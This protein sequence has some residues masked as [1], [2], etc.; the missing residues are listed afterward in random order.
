[1]RIDR[2]LANMGCGSRTEVKQLIKSGK[3]KVNG[4]T[5]IDPGHQV[6]PEDDEIDLKGDRIVY[7]EFL[8][9][10]MNKPA[11]VISAT[12][13][14]KEQTVLDLIESKY[15]NKGLFPVGRLD[16]DTEGLL[17]LTNH[18]ELGHQLLSPKKHVYKKYLARIDGKVTGQ[19]QVAFKS[20]IELDDGY[21]TLPGDLEII[22][23]G[24]VS[25]VI[26]KIR[27]CKFHQ[28]KRMF[29]AL[30]KRVVYL[31]RISMGGL[32]LD[33]GLNPGEYRE[34]TN[35]EVKQLSENQ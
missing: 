35:G 10:M 19:D 33:P 6:Q 25:E 15:H 11:G 30:E 32:I 13:D 18:G 9:L 26:V 2:F 20:G 22:S 27:E 16:K 8:Y 1:M 3:V 24:P 28:I 34:L 5:V 23:S 29:Q 14:S 17:I 12:E 31:K 4:K 21:L 7:R